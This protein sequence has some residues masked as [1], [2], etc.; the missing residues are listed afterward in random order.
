M[1]AKTLLIL[2]FLTMSILHAKQ[3]E[4]YFSNNTDLAKKCIEYVKQESLSIRIV[5]HRLS[6]PKVIASLVQAY[7]RG[8]SV[9]VIVD[10]KTVT[11]RSRLRL[12]AEEGAGVFVWKGSDRMHHAFCLF[13]KD[14]LWNGSYTFSLQKKFQHREGVVIVSDSRISKIFFDEF[15]LIKKEYTTPFLE[16]I[17]S[18]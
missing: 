6:D 7:K 12:L 18:L 4:V 11:K 10:P 16:Y 13:G 9:E 17:E 5:S 2:A 8:V 3:P 14:T 15:A 1:Q